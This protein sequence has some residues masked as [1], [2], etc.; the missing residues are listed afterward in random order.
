[1]NGVKA[2]SMG[3]FHTDYQLMRDIEQGPATWT[4]A[5]SGSCHF[6][7][8]EG[9]E[10]KIGRDGSGTHNPTNVVWDRVL[11]HQNNAVADARPPTADCH[12]GGLFIITGD[13]ITIRN[14]VFSKNWV[15][16]I[17]EQA[18][19]ANPKPTGITVENNWFANPVNSLDNCPTGCT[20]GQSH[21]Q[22]NNN[23]TTGNI[24]RYNSF[25]TSSDAMSCT[26]GSCSYSGVVVVGNNGKRPSNGF[27]SDPNQPCYPAAGITF[28]YN[29]W[30]G[31]TCG[32][33]DV[34]IS[35]TNL[36]VSETIGS[37][38]LHLGSATSGDNIVTPTSS[39]YTVTTDIDAQSRTA[40]SRD[41]GSDER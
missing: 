5:G 23:P 3:S 6:Q 16:N 7:E 17:Q 14:S 12:G 37:E 15:Y 9:D 39:D 20:T 11:I 35:S 25:G 18:F 33:G 30:V 38:D 41:A 31:R 34:S 27:G 28:G 36:Y 10:N 21:Y 13:T 26:S 4:T 22:F 1:V 24:F 29:A 8:G 19:G 2:T 40:G 32:T